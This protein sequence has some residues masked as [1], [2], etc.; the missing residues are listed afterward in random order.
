MEDVQEKIGEYLKNG[1]RLVW[2]VDPFQETVTAYRP[3][4]EPVLFSRSERLT[5]DPELPGFSVSVAELFG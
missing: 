2:L 1:T 3:N 4:A 5:G